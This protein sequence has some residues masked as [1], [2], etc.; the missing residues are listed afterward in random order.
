VNDTVPLHAH[1]LRRGQLLVTIGRVRA[2]RAML[3]RLLTRPE[4]PSTSQAEANRVLGDLECAAGR[5]RR[6]RR[7]FAAA[8]GLRP[9]VAELYLR[10]AAAVEA[11]PKANPRKGLAALR[12]AIC[13]EPQEPGHWT[14]RGR[15][16][17][18]AGDTKQARAAFRRA[19]R[20]HPE[21]VT[22]LA[23]IVDGFVA[24]GRENEA[25]R[26]LIAARFRAPTDAGIAQLWN[27]FRFDCLRLEQA[28]AG[29]GARSGADMILPF[30]EPVVSSGPAEGP[31]VVIRAD[32]ISRP[33]PHL[34]RLFPVNR[35]GS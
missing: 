16:A 27:Q 29:R 26:V 9:Y 11:D 34:L 7:Y 1:L 6:A 25:R 3:R 30:P 8:I 15:L 35:H 5:F 21:T 10:F 12:R 23:E 4:V 33:R 18:R 13:L 19:A 14:A 17:L 31:T 2:A 28:R 20:L 32:R 22:V 24:T